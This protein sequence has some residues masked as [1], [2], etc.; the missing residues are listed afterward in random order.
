MD[1]FEYRFVV[2]EASKATEH[3][4]ARAISILDVPRAK[5]TDELKRAENSRGSLII[6][7]EPITKGKRGRNVEYRSAY[8]CIRDIGTQSTK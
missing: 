6:V 2:V 8:H 5:W 4:L 7:A 3:D 1:E